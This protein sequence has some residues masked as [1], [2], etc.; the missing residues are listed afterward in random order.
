MKEFWKEI[1][2]TNPEPQHQIPSQSRHRAIAP[3]T[4]EQRVAVQQMCQQSQRLFSG[5]HCD[6]QI[7]SESPN[8]V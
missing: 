7:L 5:V 1:K 3:P 8:K 4:S 6:L 2:I